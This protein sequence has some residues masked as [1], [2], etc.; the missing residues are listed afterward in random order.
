MKIKEYRNFPIEVEIAERDEDGVRFIA[1]AHHLRSDING[2]WE[3]PE[4]AVANIKNVIDTF[5]ENAP[6]GYQELATQIE[7]S[8][9]WEQYDYCY[10]DP[11]ILK[12]II[13]NF[14]YKQE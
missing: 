4:E 1:Y 5:L 7:K 8:L 14:M 3:K 2:S 11:D 6:K 12:I 10:I 9:V 13:E